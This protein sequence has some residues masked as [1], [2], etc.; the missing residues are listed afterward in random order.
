ML[1]R[2]DADHALAEEERAPLQEVDLV[3]AQARHRSKQENLEQL[4]L[5]GGEFFL[6]ALDQGDNVERRAVARRRDALGLDAGEG[7]RV[8]DLDAYPRRPSNGFGRSR[9][10]A[11]IQARDSELSTYDLEQGPAATLLAG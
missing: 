7:N 10:T 5:L 3:A 6:R 11:K 2:L 9:S 8:G 1:R 4:G